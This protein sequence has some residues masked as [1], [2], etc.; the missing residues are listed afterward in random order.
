MSKLRL[1]PK[2][3]LMPQ[4]A[5]LVGTVVNGV[6]NAMVAAWCGVAN[7]APP[8]VSLAVRPNRH[9]EAGIRTR[10]AFSLN[11]APTALVTKVDRCGIVSGAKV[12]K[13]GPFTW[14]RGVLEGAPLIEECPLILE[15]RLVQTLE[16]P[17]HH[18][19]LAEVVEVHAEEGCLVDG[20]PDM[21]KVDPLLYSFSDGNYWQVGAA[22]GKAFH[23]GRESK[24]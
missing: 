17:T 20:A 7:H 12:D 24:G 8:M 3:F 4:P 16:L 10:G 1:G 11:M 9:T 6:P 5:V 2:A 19:H 21:G 23:L 22:L 15:C 18:L 13:S 14:G